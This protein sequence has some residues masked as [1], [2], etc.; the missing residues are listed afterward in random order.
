MGNTLWEGEARG[1]GLEFPQAVSLTKVPDLQVPLAI[2]P[3][4]SDILPHRN[5]VRSVT[6]SRQYKTLKC[7]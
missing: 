4:A 1:R 5:R 7:H 6:L 3:C 2:S